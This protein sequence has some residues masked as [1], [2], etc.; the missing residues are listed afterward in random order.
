MFLGVTVI[1]TFRSSFGLCLEVSSSMLSFFWIIVVSPFRCNR[2]I[3][4]WSINHVCITWA[5]KFKLLAFPWRFSFSISNVTGPERTGVISYI[6]YLMFIMFSVLK[7][8][9]STVRRKRED[10]K[11]E[12][13]AVRLILIWA[14]LLGDR[15]KGFFTCGIFMSLMLAE[16]GD[17]WQ[18]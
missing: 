7:I 4:A 12:Q 16:N 13:L 15:F 2:S 5:E 1:Q 9:A 14:Q 18:R 6:A 17:E 10:W 11:L 8:L 3:V